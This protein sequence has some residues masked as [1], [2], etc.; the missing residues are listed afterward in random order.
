[1]YTK[2]V[3]IIDYPILFPAGETEFLSQGLGAL[4]DAVSCSV[5]WESNGAYELNMQYP[6]TGIHFEEITDRCIIFAKPN[7]YRDPQPF[8]V[9][10][11]TVP[12][13]GVVTYYAQHLSYDLS[14]IPV[15]P[16]SAEGVAAALS[17]LKSNSAV[18]NPFSFWTDKT[19]SAHFSVDAPASIRSR[20]GGNE[21]S[22]LDVYGGE[23]IFDRWTVRLY[24]HAGHDNGVT[25]RY[26]KNLTDIE[27]DRDI[28]NVR[29]GILPYWANEDQ[30]VLCS[31]PVVEAEGTF[32]FDNVEVVDFSQD[33][34]EPP[35]A[36]Q[37]KEKAEQY[38]SDND[39]GKPNVSITVSFVELAKTDQYKDMA[40]LERCDWYD[41]IS[42]IYEQLG[43]D[44][45]A[46]VVSTEYDVLSDTYT[47]IEVGSV[48][49]NIADTI[50]QQQQEIAQ[51]PTT[52][53]M[54]I[55]ISNATNWIT[56]ANGGYIVI[57]RTADGTPYE[58]LIMDTPD[59]QTA[60]KVW[61]WNQGGLGYSSNGYNGPY[62]TAIT[63][64]GAI[65][66]DF[67]T[68]G[69][70]SANLIKTGV[71]QS[72]DGGMAIDI[73]NSDLEFSSSNVSGDI[74]SVNISDYGISMRH[75]GREIGYFNVTAGATQQSSM[76][77]AGALALG[78]FSGSLTQYETVLE[79]DL[80][81]NGKFYTQGMVDRIST[82]QIS[83]DEINFNGEKISLATY[84]PNGEGN[85]PE[86][87]YLR[88]GV[89]R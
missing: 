41:D 19:T 32:G 85:T 54:D 79:A 51:R 71:I 53:A 12:L 69:T 49:A 58:L 30:T 50:S 29:T 33:F 68:T 10:R 26:G 55:A 18:D 83:A 23:Y 38:I 28:S 61:R 81:E 11:S 56:G 63:Q 25:I 16:F 6:V 77:M 1:M 89:D 48:R 78:V 42:V 14:G 35:T 34:E 66:A 47:S 73:D 17:G 84:Y 24:N 70:L 37:L 27:Q 82:S 8:R 39:I 3:D 43:V 22:V 72:P 59:I 45:K 21:G 67:I 80:D 7:P 87:K 52:G 74:V 4:S 13:N 46:K 36:E 75:N 5:S 40:V 44:A 86:I 20:L 15:T 31:P 2:V 60:Q 9:Y 64:D 57:R 65:V 88:W 76:V 62:T